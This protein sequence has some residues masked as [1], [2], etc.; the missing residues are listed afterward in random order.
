MTDVL[1][2]G[3]CKSFFC[4]RLQFGFGFTGAET[5]IPSK[6]P[7]AMWE[8]A[9]KKQNRRIAA[10]LRQQHTSAAV[11]A[12]MPPPDDA[13]SRAP[14][15]PPTEMEVLRCFASSFTYSLIAPYRAMLL[16]ISIVRAALQVYSYLTAK[17]AAAVPAPSSSTQLDDDDG[18]SAS[19]PG[20]LRKPL[21]RRQHPPRQRQQQQQ[22]QQ[23]LQQADEEKQQQLL[24]A[25]TS[26]VAELRSLARVSVSDLKAD[27][28]AAAASAPALAQQQTQ[29][30]LPPE[31]SAK[32]RDLVAALDAWEEQRRRQGD[33]AVGLQYRWPSLQS[34]PHQEQ[35]QKQAPLSGAG[36]GL[37]EQRPEQP[38]C[39]SDDVTKLFITDFLAEAIAEEKVS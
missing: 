5:L 6:S 23:P 15:A 35:E 12:A 19:G 14:C 29:P 3:F 26:V 11:P 10:I 16:S 4:I 24:Q 30:L 33:A 18:A 36:A 34:R 17:L 7:E 21:Q 2:R 39:S 27:A 28:A 32:V 22:Q 20:A 8:D 31:L 38:A 37:G 25:K 13:S 9:L 1:G